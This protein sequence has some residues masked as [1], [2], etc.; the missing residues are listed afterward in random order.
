MLLSL[1]L[2]LLI[3]HIGKYGVLSTTLVAN[4]REIYEFKLLARV[5][6]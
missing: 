3:F 5:S 1:V 4:D 6:T 2:L